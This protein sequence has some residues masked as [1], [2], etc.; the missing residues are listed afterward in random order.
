MSAG[1]YR[2]I[3]FTHQT[4]AGLLLDWKYKSLRLKTIYTCSF[5]ITP[6]SMC[7]TIL[8]TGICN[9]NQQLNEIKGF[10]NDLFHNT[11]T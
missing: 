11:S 7:Q 8:S 3:V 9:W 6:R 4:S 5:S 10:E 2:A 1:T